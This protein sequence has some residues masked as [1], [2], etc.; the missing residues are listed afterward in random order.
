MFYH[1]NVIFIYLKLNSITTNLSLLYVENKMVEINAEMRFFFDNFFK[2]IKF[3]KP[4]AK[5]NYRKVLI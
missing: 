3:S 4:A 5:K 1:Q 2:S